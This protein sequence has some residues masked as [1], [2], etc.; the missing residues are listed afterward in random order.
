MTMY[1]QD[2]VFVVMEN[3][4]PPGAPINERYD[5]KVRACVCVDPP[6]WA[7]TRAD[8]CVCVCM[9]VCVCVCESVGARLI[10]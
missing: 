1:S 7:R 6:C 9:C 2:I 5:L 10:D 8:V 4:F 3:M